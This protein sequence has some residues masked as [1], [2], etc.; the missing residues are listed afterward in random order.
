MT[1]PRVLGLAGHSGSGKTTLAVALVPALAARGLRVAYVKH[2]AHRFLMDKPGKDTFRVY[3]AGARA[4]TIASAEQWAW[5]QRP[6]VPDIEELARRARRAA[7]VVLIEGYHDSS[8]PKVLIYRRGL[9]LRTVKPWSTVV[10]VYGDDPRRF[11]DK[12]PARIPRFPFDR[13]AE[14]IEFLFGRG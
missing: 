7:D 9:P 6:P 12:P 3:E 14:L 10:A 5:L 8:Y 2:D 13:T 1:F 4:V 11:K